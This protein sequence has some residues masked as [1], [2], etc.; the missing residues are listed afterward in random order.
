MLDGKPGTDRSVLLKSGLETKRWERDRDAQGVLLEERYFEEGALTERTVY[1]GNG[2]IDRIETILEGKTAVTATFVRAN[3]ILKAIETRDSSGKLVYTDAYSYNRDGSL[4]KTERVV[5]DPTSPTVTESRM[6]ILKSR[7]AGTWS[8]NGKSG[9]F[10]TFDVKGNVSLRED[11]AG[12]GHVTKRETFD[13][14]PVTGVLSSSFA[15]LPDEK[16]ETR[17]WYDA[18]G[19]PAAR[20]TRENGILE[21]RTEYSY[22]EKNRLTL[23]RETMG[24]PR[25]EERYGYDSS[26]TRILTETFENS[27]KVKETA[28]LADG[29]RKETWFL[30]DVPV[31]VRISQEGTLVREETWDKGTLVRTRTP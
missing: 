11:T 7:P 23:S 30:H 6:S 5:N 18:A 22:D 3:G 20:E 29:S 24:N 1:R 4:K 2:T 9:A 19:N 31:L 21:T 26:D 12:D 25:L 15:V 27:I 14:D 28:I 17:V 8:G 10:E 16:S 13:Y